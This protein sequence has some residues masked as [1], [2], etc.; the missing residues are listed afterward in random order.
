MPAVT[1]P[2]GLL[3]AGVAMQGLGMISDFV[4][5]RK[6]ASAA[7]KA[8][9]KQASDERVITAERIRQLQIEERTLRGE[10]IAK[11]AGSHVKV[12]QGSPLEI[13]A[14]Q[15]REFSKERQ[16]T[17][18]VGATKA[19]AALQRGRDVGSIAKYQSYSNIA[20]G[21]SQIFNIMSNSGQQSSGQ[22]NQGRTQL[23]GTKT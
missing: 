14:E 18:Q 19:A 11:V 21:A 10:T 17:G 13:L 3:V 7:K 4:G 8:G 12:G 16:I 2:T 22:S 23:I 6:A 1:V 5:G 20:Q 15:A 9:K